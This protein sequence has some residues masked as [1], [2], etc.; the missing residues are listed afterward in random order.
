MKSKDEMIQQIKVLVEETTLG[1]YKADEIQTTQKLQN[2]FGIDSLDYAT[3]MLRLEEWCGI[4]IKED[5]IN[6]S[7]VQSIEELAS[8]FIKQQPSAFLLKGQCHF[9]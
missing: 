5:G 8:L 6:W 9:P 3:I 2:D 7:E 4:K 1:E